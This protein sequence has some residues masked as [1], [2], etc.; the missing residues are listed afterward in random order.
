MEKT[1]IIYARVS[2][3]GQ[4]DGELP[5]ESQLEVC[6]RKAKE[7]DAVVLREFV[8]AGISA[9]TDDRA[10]FQEAVAFCRVNSVNYF[11]CW[12]TAR[13]AR[14]RIDA[15][16]H[17][18]QLKKHGTDMAYVGLTLDTST[19]EG[20]MMEGM[21]EIIDEYYSRQVSD[22]TIRSM[23]KNAR[24]GF[25]NG[26]GVP[27]GY[28]VAQEGKRRRLIILD[29]EAEIVR[30]IF[31]RYLAGAG[32]KSIACWMN[33]RG[34]LRRGARWSKTTITAMLKN[35]VYIGY[36]VFNRRDRH[37]KRM[38]PESEWI[39][40]KSHAEI[41]DEEVFM[42]TQNL[43]DSRSPKEG[44]GSHKSTHLFTGML[45]CG[46]CGKTMMIE[47]ATGRSRSYSYYNCSGNI[48]GLGCRARRIPSGEFDEWLAEYIV[49]QI[50]SIENLRSIARDIER[51]SGEWAKERERRRGAFVAELRDVEARRRRLY[52]LLETTDKDSFNLG[53]LKP[54]LMDLNSRTR[55]IESSLTELELQ[56]PPEVKASDIELLALQDFVRDVVLQSNNPQ[57]IR[58]FLGTFIEAIV[59]TGSEARICY[60]KDR[61]VTAN[62]TETV[63]SEKGWL[64]GR[65]LLRTGTIIALLPDRFR[66]AA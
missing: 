33:Q 4:A 3:V 38:R 45:K 66:R 9:R 61:L 39:R 10:A 11:I 35:Q 63:H 20:W 65:G 51:E 15:P 64:P 26:G 16:W 19:K 34:M 31:D 48:K 52:N 36:I 28:T 14:N 54:R 46:A 13:F 56:E 23:L 32:A 18:V 2:T 60:R 22:D 29:N 30:Q 7:L 50:M 47:T 24:D 6:R 43:I 17:K 27:F 12:N 57:K 62:A 21:L 5:V 41:I 37:A 58:E 8:D 49:S 42:K 25:Y 40:T 59:V 53:D 44:H 1:A 55:A